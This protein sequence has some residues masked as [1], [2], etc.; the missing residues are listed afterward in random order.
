MRGR[1]GSRCARWRWRTARRRHAALEEAIYAGHQGRHHPAP[2]L[3]RRAGGRARCRASDAPAGAAFIVAITEPASLGLLAAPGSYG[4]DIVAAEGQSLGNPIGYGGPRSGLFAAK[5]EY[6]RRMPGRLVGKTVDNRGQTG[7]VLTLQTR[8]QQI[9]RE[10]ATSNICTNQALLAVAA[11]I[12]LAAMG[13]QG[14]RE[15]GEQCLRRAHYARERITSVAGFTLLFDRPHFDEFAVATPMPV[16]ELNAA[17]RDR[18]IL[19]GYDLS[20]DYPELGH[21]ALFCVTET[22]TREEIEALV[23]ALE[24][25][26][27]N[28]P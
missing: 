6:L 26:A 13:K 3:S 28:D 15:L 7:Y 22:R 4:A 25:I 9:K 23:T 20:R 18:G 12:Y 24:E 8:E 19:G 17:L 10:R 11:T 5:A 2:E 21:A 16:E 1:A 27:G 14:F